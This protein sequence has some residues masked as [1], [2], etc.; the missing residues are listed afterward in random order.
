[1]NLQ[2]RARSQ[3]AFTELAQREGAL[4]KAVTSS[5]TSGPS[6]LARMVPCAR[7]QSEKDN[8]SHLQ[9]A[10]CTNDIKFLQSNTDIEEDGVKKP[11]TGDKL[12][13]AR[14]RAY[15]VGDLDV[16]RSID[17]QMA[18]LAAKSRAGRHSAKARKRALK[19]CI[20]SRM[21][22]F[23]FSS[24]PFSSFIFVSRIMSEL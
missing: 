10:I 23:R 4:E 22:K 15:N 2:L 7:V 5:G 3:A 17:D 19:E 12:I 20:K 8:E 16:A 13:T 14:T 6:A 18:F 1:M 9:P 24:S 21:M 11:T